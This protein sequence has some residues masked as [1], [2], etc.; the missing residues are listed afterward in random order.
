[1]TNASAQAGVRFSRAQPVQ[2][3]ERAGMRAGPGVVAG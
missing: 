3:K 2:Q 1:M